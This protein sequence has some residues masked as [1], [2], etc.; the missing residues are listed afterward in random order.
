MSA[1]TFLV[2]LSLCG[3]SERKHHL[4][5]SQ[6]LRKCQVLGSLSPR[7]LAKSSPNQSYLHSLHVLLRMEKLNFDFLSGALY[8]PGP[9]KPLSCGW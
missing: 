8:Q 5:L 1:A 4:A 3:C 2:S 9:G 6:L 7:I